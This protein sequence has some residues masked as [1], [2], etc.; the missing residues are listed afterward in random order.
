MKSIMNHQFSEIPRPEIQRSVF[1]R[2]HGHK[3][4]F[5]C[6]YLIPVYVDEALPGDTFKMRHSMLARL[7]TP[8][9]PI[10]DNVFLDTFYFAVPYRLVWENWE[11]FNGAQVDPGDSTDY[12]IPQIPSGA[13]FTAG[14]LADYFGLP[15]GV[16]SIT[17]STLPFRAYNLI[18]NEWFR[19]QNIQDSQPVDLDDG[20]DTLSDYVLLTRGKRHDYFTSCLPWPQKGDA[21]SIP[22]GDYAPVIGNGTTMSLVD[23]AS[24][25]A[26][27][28][29]DLA[30]GSGMVVQACGQVVGDPIGTATGASP[31][32]SVNDNVG[33]GL[34]Q[35]PAYS[36]MIADLSSAVASTVNELRAA[37]QVQKM[38]E[39]DAR[40][41]TRYVEIIKAHFGVVS[42]DY[43]MQRP[44]YLGG[45]SSRVIINPVTQNYRSDAGETPQGNLAAYGLAT[46]NGGFTKTFTEHCIIIGL[47]NIRADITY[48]RGINR[49]WSRLTRYDF[50]WPAFSH[51]GEQA[52]LNKEIFADGSS[53]DDEV[54]GYQERYA[55]YR[56]KPSIITGVFRS[57]HAQ[58]LNVWHLAPQ[59]SSLPALDVGFIVSNTPMDR[60]IAVPS[61]PHFLFD[62]Y[63]DL[64]CARPMP[65]Y[66]V[67]GMIDHF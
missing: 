9:K 44:E 32:T 30:Y 53:A 16:A 56:Y 33:L 54:F 61:E 57:V 12:E 31:S 65:V 25:H 23:G 46:D 20:P 39:R 67:P 1:N 42:P 19:D 60:C 55:E 15:T 28:Y 6:D 59:M 22:I 17:V 26:G 66:S 52:V 47:V 41:G 43:R 5:D 10:M 58:T 36:G 64:K 49:M 63:F 21:V 8:I 24:H 48:E 7:A 4:T 51:L 13:G 45:S 14:S 38:F 3:T 50:Y 62:S 29:M 34:S 11:K 2:S 27:L 40:G 18:W 37:W 35:N